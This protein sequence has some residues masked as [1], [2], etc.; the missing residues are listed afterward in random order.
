[1]IFFRRS[2][3][4]KEIELKHLETLN[5]LVKTNILKDLN[6]AYESRNSYSSDQKKLLFV[7]PCLYIQGGAFI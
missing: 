7:S 2:Y 5:R 1:M 4:T 6:T 3:L